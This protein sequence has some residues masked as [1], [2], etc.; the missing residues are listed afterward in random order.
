MIV[1]REPDMRLMLI[2]VMAVITLCLAETAAA[3]QKTRDQ[4]VREDRERVTEQ[5]F[6]IDNDLNAAFAR[7]RTSEKPILAVLPCTLCEE[8]LNLDADPVDQD[9]V[10]KPVLEKF[11]CV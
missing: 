4:N 10:L 8:W 6:W 1:L 5:G 2:V 7:A 9:P 11:V 3:Q